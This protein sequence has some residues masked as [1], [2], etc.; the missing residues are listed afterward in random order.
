MQEHLKIQFYYLVWRDLS[1]ISGWCTLFAEQ[2]YSLHV[3]FVVCS[4]KH[5]MNDT[6]YCILITAGCLFGGGGMK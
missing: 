2:C 3:V 4:S 1:I 6:T 5:K